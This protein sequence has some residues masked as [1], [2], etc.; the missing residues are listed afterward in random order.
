Q[1]Y[2]ARKLAA[3]EIEG[4]YEEHYMRIR[5][6]GNEIL[7]SNKGSTFILETERCGVDDLPRFQIVYICLNGRR[8]RFLN[9][10]RPIIHLDD[11]H[12]KGP[13]RDLKLVPV[14]RVDGNDDLFPL[15]YG[16]TEGETKEAS[17]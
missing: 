2:R 15:A 17:Q 16:E 5:D 6:Y 11:C 4:S 7:K 8:I 13:C 9:G 3:K 12:L 1:E 10:Y 14:I